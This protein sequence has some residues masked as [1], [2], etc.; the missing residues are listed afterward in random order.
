MSKILIWQSIDRTIL[1]L[2]FFQNTQI[3]SDRAGSELSVVGLLVHEK[4]L[5]LYWNL[6]KDLFEFQSKVILKPKSKREAILTHKNVEKLKANPLSKLT[7]RQ[8]L[9]QHN[10]INDPLRL[11]APF[12]VKAKNPNARNMGLRREL[13][14]G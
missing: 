3:Y 1:K 10:L 7:R 13:I 4:G 14:M 2:G 8:A 11:A 5:G 6:A 9:S 12:T